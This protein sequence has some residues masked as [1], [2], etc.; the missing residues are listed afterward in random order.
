MHRRPMEVRLV[1]K[2]QISRKSYMKKEYDIMHEISV[3]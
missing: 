3:P 1:L 2:L